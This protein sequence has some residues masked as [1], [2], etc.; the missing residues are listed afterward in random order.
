MKVSI[1]LLG[2]SAELGPDFTMSEA[3]AGTVEEDEAAKD[4]FGG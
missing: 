2:V 1:P 4:V 3:N